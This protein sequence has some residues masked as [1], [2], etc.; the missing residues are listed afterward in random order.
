L[1][2]SFARATATTFA[3]AHRDS[4]RHLPVQWASVCHP[5]RAATSRPLA[6]CRFPC[7]ALR[8]RCRRQRVCRSRLPVVWGVEADL[9][10]HPW[11]PSSATVDGTRHRSG[12]QTSHKPWRR[13]GYPSR[14]GRNPSC[15][16]I[17][18]ASEICAHEL[19]ERIATGAW[20][21]APSPHRSPQD[22]Y[23]MR[24]LQPS[25][26]MP[27]HTALI[28]QA[29]LRGDEVRSQMAVRR[30]E[31]RCRKALQTPRI[32]PSLGRSLTATPRSLPWKCSTN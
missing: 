31:R 18:V 23:C 6:R 29:L 25:A 21:D 32:L 16:S 15:T 19:G 12:I 11:W 14:V 22:C 1:L 4:R 5:N 27:S 7:A 8:R 10:R 13:P 9:S 28:L 20:T 17:P 26:S 24:R 3:H 2:E 30:R